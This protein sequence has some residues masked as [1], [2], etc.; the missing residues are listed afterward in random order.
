MVYKR[1]SGNTKAPFPCRKN[2][3]LRDLNHCQDITVRKSTK[4][5]SSLLPFEELNMGNN[6][7]SSNVEYDNRFSI[8]F[9]LQHTLTKIDLN[10]N[11]LDKVIL[12]EVVLQPTKKPRSVGPHKSI[13]KKNGNKEKSCLGNK[14]FRSMNKSLYATHIDIGSNNDYLSQQRLL[15]TNKDKRNYPLMSTGT[16]IPI[17]T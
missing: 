1:N 15:Y 16:S 6:H 17:V 12:T 8:N 3:M 9:P 14:K 13:S 11:P 5:K 4:L 10:T 7:L 2:R